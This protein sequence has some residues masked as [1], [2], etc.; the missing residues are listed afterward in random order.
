ALSAWLLLSC[1]SLRWTHWS[2][3]VVCNSTVTPLLTACGRRCKNL[4]TQGETSSVVRRIVSSD[5]Q[6]LCRI[7]SLSAS[8]KTLGIVSQSNLAQPV[9]MCDKVCYSEHQHSGHDPVRLRGPS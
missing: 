8:R 5:G 2:G 7:C 1:C 3:D 4:W 6:G 9:S